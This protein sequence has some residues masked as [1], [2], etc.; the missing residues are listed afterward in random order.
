LISTTTQQDGTISWRL[1]P[2]KSRI[3]I[4]TAIPS[5]T[6]SFQPALHNAST[7]ENLNVNFGIGPMTLSPSQV[8]IQLAV[9]VYYNNG[10]DAID[11]INQWYVK[12]LTENVPS[13]L[14]YNTTNSMQAGA[15][16]KN[17]LN[18]I[19][20]TPKPARP[21]VMAPM[22][23]SVLLSGNSYNNMRLFSW[24]ATVQPSADYFAQGMAAFQLAL[25]APAVA[26]TR[27]SVLDVLAAQG[28]TVYNESEIQLEGYTANAQNLLYAAPRMC[29]LGETSSSPSTIST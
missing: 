26:A 4:S 19:Q 8:T 12:P 28:L 9:S 15:L 7:L 20:L 21:D 10:T 11:S 5:K 6:T 18:G 3:S 1:D 17:V 23:L 13:G 16:V 2:G 25:S 27:S 22:P 14:W 29:Y 24:S